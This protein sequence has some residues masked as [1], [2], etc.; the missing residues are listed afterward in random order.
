EFKPV[1][2]T[3]PS[4][5]RSYAFN[6]DADA[7]SNLKRAEK[8]K[9]GTQIKTKEARAGQVKVFAPGDDI[10]TFKQRDPDA[11][12]MPWLYL[13]I[14]IVLIVEQA[15]AVHLSFHLKPSDQA[16]AAPARPQPAAA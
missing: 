3:Q 15:L 2:A 6:I 7:E 8:D 1:D 11:S 12:E 16:A 5:F 9:L 4:E 14:L 10:T 13:L